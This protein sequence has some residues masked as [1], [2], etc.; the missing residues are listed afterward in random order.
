MQENLQYF[1]REKS[2]NYFVKY[3]SFLLTTEYMMFGNKS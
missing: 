3:V 2:Q 1:Q